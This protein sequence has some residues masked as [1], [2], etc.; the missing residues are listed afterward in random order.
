MSIQVGSARATL[1]NKSA[2]C[3]RLEIREECVI[4]GDIDTLWRIVSN[5]NAWPTWDPHQKA[6]EL[7]GA[8]VVGAIGISKRR[9]RPS[10]QWTLTKVERKKGWAL[11]MQ[12]LIGTIEKEIRYTPL[13]GGKIHCDDT[14]LVSGPLRFL[15]W[16][17]FE[18]VTRRNMQG[19][20]AKLEKE[21]EKRQV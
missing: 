12:I 11:K 1:A 19:T 15:F 2:N 13:P 10:A 5:V 18:R 14:M 6:T 7:H 17:C 16:L 20:W 4:T 8:F 9:G 3:G 21:I